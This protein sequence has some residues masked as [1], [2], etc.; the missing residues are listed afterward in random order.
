MLPDL[1][2]RDLRPELMDDPALDVA[3][4]RRAL[5]GLARINRWSFAPSLI[6]RH[7]AALAAPPDTPLR[8]V[9]VACGSG[10]LLAGLA[11]RADRPVLL[12]GCDVSPTALRAAD[13]RLSTAGHEGT[14]ERID[15]LS[16]PLPAADVLLN[17]LFLHHLDRDQAVAFLAKLAAVPAAV[18]LCDLRRT[19][20]GWL[21]AR[22]GT[23]LLSRSPVVHYDGPQSVRA[24]WTSAEIHDLAAAAGIAGYRL[25]THFPQRF[26]L[27]WDHRDGR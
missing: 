16:D 19:R 3:E 11:G 1:R 20:R 25:T 22:V 27:S 23:R 15:V 4:H 10:D 14:F 26:V 13:E 2:S 8:I 18:V 9:D 24:A 12:G 17:S 5:A 6:W 7:V 21:L